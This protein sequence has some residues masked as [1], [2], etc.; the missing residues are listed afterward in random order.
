V[1]I[2]LDYR[3][4]LRQRTGVGEYVHE[5]AR[6]LVASAPPDESLQLFSASWRDR[7]PPGILPGAA[8]VDR[9]IP[10][11]ALNF[12]WHRLGW[13]P[14]EQLAR[15]SLDVVQSLHPLLM[16]ARAAAQVV[17]IHDLDFLDHP[18]RTRAEIR[19][20][21]PALAARHAARADRV[22][23]V[24]RYTA[25]E[26]ERRLGVPPAKISI[27][28]PGAPAWPRRTREPGAGYILFLGTLEPRKNLDV[29]V[30][31]YERL[32]ARRP[33]APRLVLAGRPTEAAAPLLNRIARSPASRAID[34]PGYIEPSRRQELYLGALALVLPSHN[35][36]FGIPAL[37]AMTC[38]VPVVAACRGA[39]PEVLGAAGR[40][41]DPL[42]AE[43]LCR[44]L[45]DVIASSAVRDRMRETGWVEAGRFQWAQT[46]ERTR[47][48]WALAVEARRSGVRLRRD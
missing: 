6:A 30:E 35:E 37:E 27:A 34:L 47:E 32:L 29:L 33:E 9:R 11:A 16:P 39:L 15:T 10:V 20:D 40:L 23:V 13:P 43:T 2:L 42:D 44:A 41:I 12:A 26:V 1:R 22:V 4:A 19:R 3:P 5:L 46:A 18:E 7:L 31:A 28:S 24:S 45:G 14:A 8:V 21:Y 25:R 48:A 38:G 17:T 36:G